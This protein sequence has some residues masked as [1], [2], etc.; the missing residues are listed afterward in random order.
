MLETFILKNTPF[1][2]S[3]N[4]YFISGKIFTR[5]ARLHNHNRKSQ[6]K[7]WDFLMYD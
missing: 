6:Y 7:H 5:Y 2:G 4:E 1:G 3:K